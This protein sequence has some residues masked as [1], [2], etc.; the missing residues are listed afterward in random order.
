MEGHWCGRYQ[1]QH[2]F[3][4]CHE[5]GSSYFLSLISSK[6]IL[7]HAYCCSI[8]RSQKGDSGIEWWKGFVEY[9]RLCFQQTLA[10]GHLAS[11]WP[12]QAGVTIHRRFRLNPS[13]QCVRIGYAISL[14]TSVVLY[15]SMVWWTQDHQW[16]SYRQDPSH[17]RLRSFGRVEGIICSYFWGKEIEE[18]PFHAWWDRLGFCL[19]R[20]WYSFHIYAA[21]NNRTN[22]SSTRPLF[23]MME[24][25]LI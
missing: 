16:G 15:K 8:H 18:S 23:S 17:R 9:P 21:P 12:R 4:W 2:L 6:G 13:N 24:K 19:S 20:W 7:T 14:S 1:P 22:I 25:L 11:G 3:D 5:V 10:M